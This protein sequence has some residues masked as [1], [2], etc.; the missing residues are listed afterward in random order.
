MTILQV[1]FSLRADLLIFLTKLI[2]I[3]AVSD[4]MRLIL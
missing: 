1:G 4:T 3:G 2:S